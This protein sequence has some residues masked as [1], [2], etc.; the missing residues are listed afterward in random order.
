MCK[1]GET[2]RRH[3]VRES[4][5]MAGILHLSI[6]PSY[7]ETQKSDHIEHPLTSAVW[8]SS[9]DSM[10]TCKLIVESIETAVTHVYA[11]ANANGV[12]II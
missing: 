6:C 10:H 2:G 4:P 7:V 12:D 1:K 5:A 9:A 11:E 3:I 8:V